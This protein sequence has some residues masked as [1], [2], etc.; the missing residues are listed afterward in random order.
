MAATEPVFRGRNSFCAAITAILKHVMTPPAPDLC[1][2]PRADSARRY[3]RPGA[4]D[5]RL[6]IHFIH[7]PLPIATTGSR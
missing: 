2:A 1:D 7:P 3:A 5:A 4:R 6:G